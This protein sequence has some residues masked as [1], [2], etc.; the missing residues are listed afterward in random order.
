MGLMH[1]TRRLLGVAGRGLCPSASPGTEEKVQ[2]EG[3]SWTVSRSP[4]G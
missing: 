2:V 4:V 1:L 3:L